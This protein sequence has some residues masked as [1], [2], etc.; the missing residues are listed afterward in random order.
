[1]N[2]VDAI[3]IG[4]GQGGVPLAI[5]LAR[6]GRNVV[7]LEREKVGG[8]CINWGCTPSKCFLAA[9]DAAGRARDAAALGIKA[10]VDVDF[11][12]VMSRARD[13]KSQWSEGDARKLRDAGVNL[14]DAEASFTDEGRVQGGGEVYSAPLVVI[15]TGTSPFT[16]PIQGL[17]ATPFLNDR[18]FWDLEELPARTIMLGGGYIGLELGQGLAQLGSRVTIVDAQPRIMSMESEDVSEV[19]ET[20]LR[21]DGVDFRLGAGVESVQFE[22][23]KFT[24]HLEGGDSLEADALYVAT[25]RKP[26]TAALKAQAAG[27]ELNAR[28]FVTVNDRFETSIPGVYA[29]GDVTGQPA[30]TH[31]SWEDNRRLLSILDGGDRR[32]GDRILGYTMFTRPQ[33]GRA[34]LSM[35]QA[36]EHGHSAVEAKIDV[37]DMTRA[38]EWGE[39]LGF[40]KM[41]IDSDSGQILGSELVCYEAGELIHV[42]LDLIEASATW[43]FLSRLQH[44]HPTYAEFMPTLAGKFVDMDIG[45]KKVVSKT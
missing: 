8:S 36:Q 22:G 28:G 1:M 43:Q 12:K 25:G 32:Q 34:G 19:I 17:A 23:G 42:F 44:I 5:E 38:I 21:R 45:S 7:A 2:E 3:L 14:V 31:V 13:I 39:D 20:A 41:V 4:T 37:K 24:M 29:I 16:P 11:A 15:N 27:L 9:A 26:N 10:Q 18:N 40:F 35:K 33:M 6:R 30:F